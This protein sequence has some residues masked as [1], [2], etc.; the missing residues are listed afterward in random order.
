MV[1]MTLPTPI[2]PSLTAKVFVFQF[3]QSVNMLSYMTKGILWIACS[4]G[5][6]SK[7]L[8]EDLRSKDLADRQPGNR[9]SVLQLQRNYI[10]PTI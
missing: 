4:E 5:D 3:L 8:R 2:P 9:N 6:R 1:S 10:Q 7:D